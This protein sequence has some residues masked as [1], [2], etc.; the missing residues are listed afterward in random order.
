MILSK[1]IRLKPTKEQEKMLYK[2]A[3][4][5]R[6]IYNCALLTQEEHFR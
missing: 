2:S 6:W 4:S 5:A 3:E 1:K